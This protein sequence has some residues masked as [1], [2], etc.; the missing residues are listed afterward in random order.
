MREDGD[1]ALLVKQRPNHGNPGY[2]LTWRSDEK[3]DI[4]HTCP[5]V[6]P[7]Q[8]RRGKEQ[9]KLSHHKASSRAA[10][11]IFHVK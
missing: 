10:V 3:V 6:F 2:T 9:S 5:P 7:D 1:T 8:S 4:P 11:C